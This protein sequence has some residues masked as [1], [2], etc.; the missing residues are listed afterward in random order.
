MKKLL[1]IILC[2]IFFDSY[3]LAQNL[4]L[5]KSEVEQQIAKK[6]SLDHVILQ[7][8]EKNINLDELKIISFSSDKMSKKIALKI[9]DDN[10]NSAT[11]IQA[12]FD[13][14]I[15]VIV[16][17][18]FIE[19]GQEINISNLTELKYPKYRVTR[20]FILEKEALLG[21][22]AK[23]NLIAGKPISVNEL[24]KDFAINKGQVVRVIYIKGNLNIE[25]KATALQ[26]GSK[27]DFIE[28]KNI[29]SNKIFTAKIIDN[30]TVIIENK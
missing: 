10:Q 27:G 13:E 18:L 22:K 12:F 26:K 17:K 1:P 24:S 5:S 30:A 19:K 8:Y 25:S 7:T 20:N 15:L 23:R 14:A 11:N 3:S 4:Y 16:P 9:L 29:D 6:N 21:K 2:I 28:I